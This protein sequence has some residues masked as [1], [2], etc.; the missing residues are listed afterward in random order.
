MSLKEGKT[1]LVMGI[2]FSL[3]GV[4][5]LTVIIPTQIKYVNGAYPQPRFFPQV[6]AALIVVLGIALFVGGIRKIKSMKEEDQEVYTFRW[7]EVR[8]VMFT[9]VVMMIYVAVLSFISYLPATMI[10][11]AVLMAAYGQ[12]SKLKLIGV[13]VLLPVRIYVGLTYGLRLRLP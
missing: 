12:R 13:S 2:L 9:L 10:A 11:L 1:E 7:N 8:L 5:L 6:I 4:L 3:F